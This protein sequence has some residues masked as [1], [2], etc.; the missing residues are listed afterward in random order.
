MRSEKYRDTEYS[1]IITKRKI[2]INPFSQNTNWFRARF[3]LWYLI[4]GV[5]NRDCLDFSTR[6]EIFAP[7][8]RN[9]LYQH[10]KSTILP[11]RRKISDK[12]WVSLSGML[13]LHTSHVSIFRALFLFT[14]WLSQNSWVS[15]RIKYLH[16]YVA[17]SRNLLVPVHRWLCLT[18]ETSGQTWF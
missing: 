4:L 15:R 18:L 3:L 9:N 8:L 14:S 11:E 17:P 13:L 2:E 6:Y 5:V 7:R 12:M 1:R 16:T 10:E